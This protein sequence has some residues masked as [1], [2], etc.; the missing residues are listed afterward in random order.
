[1][2]LY[3]REF[4]VAR[5]DAGYLRFKDREENVL[6]IYPPDKH[7]YYESQE[8]FMEAREK[9]LYEGLMSEEEIFWLLQDEGVW[10]E[11]MA[12]EY[13]DLPKNIESLKIQ[14]YEAAFKS[15]QRKKLREYLKLSKEEY[16]RLHG[17]RHSW[18][19]LS[20]EG[21]AS[22]SRWL[23]IIGNSVYNTD[24]T[25][26]DWE[27]DSVTRVMQFFHSQS[28]TEE[29][30]RELSREDP[31]ASTW[32]MR[33]RSG[34][35]FEEPYTIEQKSLAMW[36]SMYENIRESPECPHDTIIKDDDMIDGWLLLQK[37]KREGQQMK[38][39]AEEYA[40][41]DK[42]KNSDEVFIP[43]ESIEDA[44]LVDSMNNGLGQA[45]KIARERK[46]RKEGEVKFQDFGDVKRRV[47]TEAVQAFR[48]AGK[49]K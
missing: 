24:G 38:S 4:L 35:I 43:V 47:Q 34:V 48:Q 22:F 33:K 18:D 7:V 26:Y 40:G 11:K 44:E 9:A 3:E 36:S 13:K 8:V 32:S 15:K 27:N 45:I 23:H 17:I 10:T 37:K 28:L 12:Q 25:K 39:R 42:V 14:I 20:A 6:R 30:V 1:M 49:G 2:K 21:V 5:I 31:W 29:V 46:V 16:E 19:Y 41:S